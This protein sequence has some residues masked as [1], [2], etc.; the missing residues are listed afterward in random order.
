MICIPIVA[1]TTEEAVAHMAQSAAQADI[2]E[3]RIDQITDVDLPRLIG[4]RGDETLILVTNRRRDEGGGFPGTEGERVR[5]LLD[6]VALGADYVDI[7]ARTERPLLKEFI[8]QIEKY[9]HRT[10]WIIS[11]H[12]FSGTPSERAL[13]KRFSAC[14]K[15]GA[16]I[17]KIVT[18]AHTVEDNLK[19]LALIP[20]ARERNQAIIALCMGEQGKISRIMAPLLGSSLSYAS[21]GKGAESA[22]GQ[23]TVAEM[24]QIYQIL[25]PS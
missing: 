20:Y 7:E 13:R 19:T 23:L 25:Q 14:H 9:G 17:V 8:A 22:P 15:H 2:L 6:A 5:L 18:Y 11:M 24:R 3:L 16:D 10:Q 21:L 1:K 4:A 12:D